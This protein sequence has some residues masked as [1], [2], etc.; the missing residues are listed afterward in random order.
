MMEA[1]VPVPQNGIHAVTKALYFGVDPKKP[2]VPRTVNVR[3]IEP[4]IAV[5][6]TLGSVD[7]G[8]TWG[9]LTG[10][11]NAALDEHERVLGRKILM[12]P[13]F[14]WQT[15]DQ[16]GKDGF[17]NY[18]T[19]L[20]GALKQKPKG[21]QLLADIANLLPVPDGY[22]PGK[23][24]DFSKLSASWARSMAFGH[25]EQLLETPPATLGAPGADSGVR[26]LILNGGPD[27]RNT[28]VMAGNDRN[29]GD[30]RGAWAAISF[31]WGRVLQAEGIL[32]R[33]DIL[34]ANLLNRA[35]G[36]L[37]GA[38]DD[39]PVDVPVS[40]KP[41]EYRT[42]RTTLSE[43]LALGAEAPLRYI[44]SGFDDFGVL[45]QA[46][47]RAPKIVKAAGDMVARFVI[48]LTAAAGSDSGLRELAQRMIPTEGARRRAWTLNE[49]AISDEH[50]LPSRESSQHVG[51][52]LYWEH[53]LLK[54][55]T[56]LTAEVVA[57]P[58]TA[59][60]TGFITHG[61][62][63]FD[64]ASKQDLAWAVLVALEAPLQKG[65]TALLDLFTLGTMNQPIEKAVSLLM[66]SN[67]Y[68]IVNSV[69]WVETFVV[70]PLM[71]QQAER[72]LLGSGIGV[73]AAV[74]TLVN[75][76]L[77][78]FAEVA[79]K[80]FSGA[81]AK[82]DFAQQ[83]QRKD[84]KENNRKKL[85]A[86]ARK[87]TPSPPPA[88]ENSKIPEYLQQGAAL[89]WGLAADQVPVPLPVPNL[90]Q[91]Q[92]GC[93]HLGLTKGNAAFSEQ[94]EQ[95]VAQHRGYYL[96]RNKTLAERVFGSQTPKVSTALGRKETAV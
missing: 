6:A 43:A 20:I 62:L 40:W 72:F 38:S 80:Q 42:V 60:A 31:P 95:Y 74:D 55:P 12:Q 82:K 15:G 53:H 35:V 3:E 88:P 4:G 19:R 56:T 36:I 49:K 13:R 33:P 37:S 57:N 39:R 51:K 14:P 64:V 66:P 59:T 17:G 68:E 96:Q 54:D 41:W 77:S 34:L 28:W 94:V 5:A 85:I 58:K 16:P 29:S 79:R 2:G 25:N 26:V 71:H 1:P 73:V 9:L 86:E 90:Q 47:I 75:E 8:Y 65:I 92:V 7:F 11:S 76:M 81:N 18:V 84:D 93:Q 48:D 10:R 32:L 70:K 24:F 52:D 30:G 23:T 83:V 61:R 91:L 45:S 89:V 78:T 21:Q 63:L 27:L 46:P 87:G 44:Q 69:R 22:T 67:L 50:G